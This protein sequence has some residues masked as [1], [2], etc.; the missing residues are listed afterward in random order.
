MPSIEPIVRVLGIHKYFTR[1]SERVDVLQ[2]L[3]L[4]VPNGEFLALMGPSGSGK[5]TLLNLIAGLD[6]PEI[7]YAGVPKV[8]FCSPEVASVGLTEAQAKDRGHEVRVL[9]LNMAVLA[10]A[11]I[12]GQGGLCKVVADADGGPILGIHL[13]GP[14]ATDLISEAMLVTNWEAGPVDLA[15]LIHPHPTLSEAMG[16]A[17][18]AL[19]GKPLH[20]A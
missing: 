15:P 1:G 9:K 10:K 7:D 6:V 5:T 13:I 12:L 4:E 20:T 14:H 18:L 17:F 16:E 2:E 11:N 19:A 3:S 8:T